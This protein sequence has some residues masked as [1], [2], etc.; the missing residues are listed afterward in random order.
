MTIDGIFNIVKMEQTLWREDVTAKTTTRVVVDIVAADMA[1]GAGRTVGA[2]VA[3][4]N[5]AS[6]WRPLPRSF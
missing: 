6:N 4:K 2:N 5:A 3:W 1:T